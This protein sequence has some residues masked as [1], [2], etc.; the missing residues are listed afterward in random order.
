MGLAGWPWPA[1]AGA[2][3]RPGTPAGPTTRVRDED[4][5]GDP[6]HVSDGSSANGGPMQVEM[7]RADR[8]QETGELVEPFV[9]EEPALCFG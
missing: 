7:K 4:G 5:V 2:L 6:D 1:R 9:D 3:A 8:L